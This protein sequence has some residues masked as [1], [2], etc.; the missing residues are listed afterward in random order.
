MKNG[1]PVKT[2][3]I[4]KPEFDIKSESS[5]VSDAKD[6]SIVGSLSHLT[7]KALPDLYVSASIMGEYIAC[8]I[9][10]IM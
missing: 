8:L 4:P 1:N 9:T 2:I 10:H 5:N 7:T 6:H 3:L